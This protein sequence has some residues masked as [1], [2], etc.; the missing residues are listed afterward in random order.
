MTR[1]KKNTLVVDDVRNMIFDATTVRTS[2]EGLEALYSQP[3]DE[4]WLDH[5]LGFA[6]DIRPLVRKVEADAHDGII[7]PVG[8]F[9]IHTGNP[10]GRWWVAKALLPWYTVATAD[11]WEW[12]EY[13]DQVEDWYDAEELEG[14]GD[15]TE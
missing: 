1:T 15:E 11:G 9:I 12:S 7:L 14:E 6:D 2:A 8:M 5:D 10:V 3:W 4:V 13:E